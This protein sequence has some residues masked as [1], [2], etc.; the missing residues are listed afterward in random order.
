MILDDQEIAEI[1]S[2]VK[3]V[4]IK[5][6]DRSLSMKTGEI[7]PTD[8]A[9]VVLMDNNK[10]SLTL[11]QWGFPKHDNKGVIINAR[12]E[13]ATQKK[14]FAT[15]FHSRRIVIPST[16]FFEWAKT[17]GKS[18]QKLQFNMP[19]SPMLYMAGL[20]ANYPVQTESQQL[21]SKFVILT[22]EANESIIDIH[23][24]MPVILHK[25]E[26]RRWLNDLTFANTIKSRNSISLVRRSIGKQDETNIP[27]QL[28]L[29]DPH[30]KS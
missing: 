22:Q 30:T 19:D 13:T 14:L 3:E 6:D 9:P 15:S 4:S 12:S 26:I 18:K 27:Q 29:C 20:Y 7:F 25:N 21:V 5:F 8:H 1:N 24:R 10:P 2:I 16:G 23:N 28:L 11:M 17:E